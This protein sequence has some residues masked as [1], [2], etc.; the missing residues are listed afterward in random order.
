MASPNPEVVL[1]RPALRDADALRNFIEGI[2]VAESSAKQL[3]FL[4]E[5]PRYLTIQGLLEAVRERAIGL[6][7]H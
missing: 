1:G 5:D 2:R 7:Q 3:A 4:R 6:V